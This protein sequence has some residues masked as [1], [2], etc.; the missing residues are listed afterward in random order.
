MI[1]IDRHR[2][3]I[4]VTGHAGYAPQGQDIVCAAVSAL[5]YTLAASIE[6]LTA[7]AMQCRMSPGMVD[8]RHGN[9]SEAAQLLVDSFFCGV[10]AIARTY[11]EYVVVEPAAGA[12]TE[13]LK[14]C[15]ESSGVETEN[16]GKQSNCFKNL[17]EL[18][19]DEHPV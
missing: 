4:T 6:T 12:G 10:E 11:P 15:G 16:Y 19:H 5:S 2:G 8:I 18:Q 3:G 1:V 9:L 7:D 14:S 13:R 17:E